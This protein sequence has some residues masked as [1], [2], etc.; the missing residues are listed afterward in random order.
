VATIE[1]YGRQL[2]P[3][4]AAAVHFHGVDPD[5]GPMLRYTTLLAREHETR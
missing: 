1:S 3:P 4:P 2:R 5:V